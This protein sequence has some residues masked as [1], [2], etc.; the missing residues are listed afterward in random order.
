MQPPDAAN[1]ITQMLQRIRKGDKQAESRLISLV[2]GELHAMAAK[3]MRR[4]KADH[5]LQPTALVNEAYIRLLAQRET[6]WQNRAHFFCVASQVMRHILVDY[7]RQRL[8]GRRGGGMVS[9]T[10]NETLVVSNS[11]LEELLVIEDA[12]Q[13]LETEDPRVA[14]V[15]VFRFFGGLS[16]EE[17]AE[18]MQLSPRTVQRDWQ[19]GRA[20]LKRKLGSRNTDAASG[21]QRH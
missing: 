16:A 9:V 5:I 3:L 10:I 2:Y 11:R 15:V 13:D 18:V 7:A 12:L 19:Y 4:E 14:R 8:S 6:D 20:W 21:S 17:I 1:D